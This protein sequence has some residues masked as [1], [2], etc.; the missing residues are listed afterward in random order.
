MGLR[1]DAIK[2]YR[3]KQ[4]ASEAKAAAE[5]QERLDKRV[6]QAQA[7][8]CK[9]FNLPNPPHLVIAHNDT[10]YWPDVS[11]EVEG[12][13][14]GYDL[15]DCYLRANISCPK[16]NGEWLR[17]FD[18]RVSADGVRDLSWLGNELSLSWHNC[19]ADHPPPPPRPEYVPPQ[20]V[21]YRIDSQEH[22]LLDS[23]REYAIGL[24]EQ[25]REGR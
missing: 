19:P 20:T 3:D 18:V 17:R 15:D 4:A 6:M 21:E 5:K 11:F 14:F 25:E 7:D 22:R 8:I 12:I 9:T 24:I 23:I 10:S 13:L 16:C 2:A 1:E